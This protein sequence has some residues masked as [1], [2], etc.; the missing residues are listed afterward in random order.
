MGPGRKEQGLDL[1]LLGEAGA[2]GLG[3]EGARVAQALGE[4]GTLGEELGGAHGEEATR[5]GPKRF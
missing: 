2:L 1:M 5:T 3:E 4:C